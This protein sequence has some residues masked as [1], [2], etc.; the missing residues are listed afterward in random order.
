MN[1]NM[2]WRS[3]FIFAIVL[4]CVYGLLGRPAFPTSLGQV[5]ENFRQ[6]IKLGLDLQGGTHMVLQVQIGEAIAQECNQTIDRFTQ[7]LR[8]KNVKVGDIR[9]ISDTQILVGNVPYEQAA[10][11]RDLA[12]SEFPEWDV[13]LATGQANGYMLTLKPARIAQIKQQTMDQSV[14]TIRRRIDALGLTEPT[15]APTGRQDTEIL[16]QL[17]GF[18]DPARAKAVIQ[19]GGQLEL[20]KVDDGPFPSEAEALASRGGILPAESELLPG[21]FEGAQPGRA[22]GEVFYLLDRIPV[23]TGRD[24]RSAN[25]GADP[26]NPGRGEGSLTI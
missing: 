5:G 4:L 13:A 14:E 10:A 6:R 16:V 24:L 12:Q 19:A 23:V 7:R 3:L 1:Q 9:R 8:D 18:G 22:A 11:F 21:K 2:K 20:R 26:D 17:P 15:I 25:P